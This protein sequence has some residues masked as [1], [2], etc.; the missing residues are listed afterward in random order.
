MRT[1]Q[2]PLTQKVHVRVSPESFVFETEWWVREAKATA[3]KVAVEAIEAHKTGCHFIGV[4]T[5]GDASGRTEKR[6]ELLH[7][8]ALTARS[9]CS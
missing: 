3:R 1:R 8:Q 4:H 2:E 9:A 6:F 5:N 7:R